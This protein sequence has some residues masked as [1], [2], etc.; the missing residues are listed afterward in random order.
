MIDKDQGV[1]H[2]IDFRLATKEEECDK[3]APL[4][5]LHSSDYHNIMPSG[6]R[7]VVITKSAF[8]PNLNVTLYFSAENKW[9]S[10]ETKSETLL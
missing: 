10:F 9:E 6:Y 4:N 5:A 8:T 2:F 1:L 3:F 7:N